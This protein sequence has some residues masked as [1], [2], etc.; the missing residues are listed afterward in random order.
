MSKTKQGVI[1]FTQIFF[2]MPVLKFSRRTVYAYCANVLVMKCSAEVSCTSCTRLALLHGKR[3]VAPCGD[4][5]DLTPWS[6]FCCL[7]G[8]TAVLRAMFPHGQSKLLGCMWLGAD[9]LLQL[10]DVL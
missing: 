8:C 10:S 6:A 7:F 9:D 2:I 1:S 3:L 4:V 5:S